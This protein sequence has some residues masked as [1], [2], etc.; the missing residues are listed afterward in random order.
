[1]ALY[2]ELALGIWYLNL[3]HLNHLTCHIKK[4]KVMEFI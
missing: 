3:A 4:T 1:L 2:V